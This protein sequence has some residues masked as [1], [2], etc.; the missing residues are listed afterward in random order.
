MTQ[1]RKLYTLSDVIELI[2]KTEGVPE[3]NVNTF[4]CAGLGI[5]NAFC[6][7][8]SI[9]EDNFIFQVDP[10]EKNENA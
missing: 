3:E 1:I 6:E 4:E 9:T 7:Y 2:A 10:L 8:E 5:N